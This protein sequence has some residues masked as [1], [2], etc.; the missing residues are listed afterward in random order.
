[1]RVRCVFILLHGLAALIPFLSWQS[2]PQ[3]ETKQFV[4]WP[5]KFEGLP[6]MQLGL[7][8]QEQLFAKDFPGQVAR[9]TDG[10]REIV[11]RWVN[12]PSRSLHPAVDCLKGVGYTIAPK[13]I[14]VDAAGN[15]WGCFAA[16]RG[17]RTLSVCERVYDEAGRS[18]SDISSWYWATLLGKTDGP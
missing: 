11:M 17:G 12:H 1:M 15:Y 9:F 4:G 14:H 2:S 13:P 18:W 6:L 16:R 5:Q 8:E 3:R 7:T 10:S